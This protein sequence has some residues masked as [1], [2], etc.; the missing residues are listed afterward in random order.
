MKHTF[1]SLILVFFLT[2][3]PGQQRLQLGNLPSGSSPQDNILRVQPAFNQFFSNLK[4]TET[5]VDVSKALGTPFEDENF[6][7]GQ[8]YDKEELIGAFYLRY[9]AYDDQIELKKTQ[10]KEE[11][12]QGLVKNSTFR[13]IYKNTDL[14]YRAFTDAKG[15]IATGYLQSLVIGDIYKLFK[16]R[17]AIFIPATVPV[18][19]QTRPTPSRFTQFE[20]FFMSLNGIDQIVEVPSHTSKFMAM[21]PKE[22]QAELK[23]YMKA[24]KIRLKQESDLINLFTYL[25][26]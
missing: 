14:S 5:K 10:L 26:R 22:I 11:P 18:N 20:S 12:I 16:R 6:S 19:P 9:N 7:K 2:P 15:N 21:F 8:L 13:A 25:T 23:K 24:N 1:V 17:K 4:S 3:C